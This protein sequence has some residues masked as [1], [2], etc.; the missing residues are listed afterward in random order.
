[1]EN[2]GFR[3]E[4]HVAQILIK[5]LPVELPEILDESSCSKDGVVSCCLSSAVVV[6]SDINTI[7]AMMENRKLMWVKNSVCVCVQ[8]NTNLLASFA[9]EYSMVAVP[10]RCLDGVSRK[11]KAN[12]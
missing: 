1:M 6:D 12:P 3:S 11:F 8:K 9:F 10:G 4:I 2:T 5:C 7:N